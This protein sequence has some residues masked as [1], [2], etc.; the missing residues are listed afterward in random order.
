MKNKKPETLFSESVN[1]SLE[2]HNQVK[3]N[4]PSHAADD[5]T[6]PVKKETA[7]QPREYYKPIGRRKLTE[8][9]KRKQFAITIGPGTLDVLSEIPD[10]KKK[11][12]HY[13]DDNVYSI[14]EELK[15][16]Y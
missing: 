15:N 6:E 3:D 14:A 1:A 8:K 11:L 5:K 2:G 9:E 4:T 16:R 7:E 13:I 12:S 10:F